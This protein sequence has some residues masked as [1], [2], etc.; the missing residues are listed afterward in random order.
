[1]KT[2]CKPGDRCVIVA[3][4]AGCECNIGARVTVLEVALTFIASGGTA[5]HWTFKDASRPLKVVEHDSAGRVIPGREQWCS[6]SEEIR[7]G[8]QLP[9]IYDQHLAPLAGDG[10][11]VLDEQREEQPA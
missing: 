1:M 3:E 9:G 4:I 5:A 11:L 7:H 2:R 10:E 6:S 8:D